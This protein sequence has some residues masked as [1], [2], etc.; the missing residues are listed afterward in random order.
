MLS[1]MAARSMVV[2]SVS[3]TTVCTDSLLLEYVTRSD[4]HLRAAQSGGCLFL[5]NLA[6]AVIRSYPSVA[7]RLSLKYGYVFETAEG[8]LPCIGPGA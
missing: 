5:R 4:M 6:Q 3:R 2:E 1:I 7:P 8:G